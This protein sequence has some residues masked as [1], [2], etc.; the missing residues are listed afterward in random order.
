MQLASQGV[1][2]R[3]LQQTARVSPHGAFVLSGD[4]ER[5]GLLPLQCFPCTY[6]TGGCGNGVVGGDMADEQ[7]MDSSHRLIAA[8]PSPLSSPSP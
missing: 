2:R 3:T 4:R 7:W 1:L 6:Q 5:G 8:H